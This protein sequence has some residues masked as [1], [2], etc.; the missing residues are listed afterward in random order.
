MQGWKHVRLSPR[1]RARQ[2]V[3]ALVSDLKD[4]WPGDGW[5]PVLIRVQRDGVNYSV[6]VVRDR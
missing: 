5:A 4:E 6:R 2:L 3:G 1:A